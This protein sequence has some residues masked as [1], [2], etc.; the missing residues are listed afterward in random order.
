[1]APL[2]PETPIILLK[3]RESFYEPLL[4]PFFN[5]AYYSHDYL[6]CSLPTSLLDPSFNLDS[7]SVFRIPLGLFLLKPSALNK[8]SGAVSLLPVSK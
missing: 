6:L 8:T 4:A 2:P 5:L 1:M 7:T 3:S